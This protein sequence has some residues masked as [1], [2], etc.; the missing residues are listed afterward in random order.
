MFPGSDVALSAFA[1][2][3][4]VLSAFGNTLD[5][6][7]ISEDTSDAA[8]RVLSVAEVSA[9][10]VLLLAAGVLAVDDA[11]PQPPSSMAA[12]IRHTRY[13]FFIRTLPP[14]VL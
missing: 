6:A 12:V 2:A 14:L 7:G 13:F 3:F 1:D 11:M 9:V 5:T 8:D 10:D 4:S